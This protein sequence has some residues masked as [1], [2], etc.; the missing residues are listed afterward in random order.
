MP[1]EVLD[2]TERSTLDALSGRELEVL[3]QAARGLSNRHIAH[4]LQLSEATVKRHLANVYNKI[5]VGSRG[6]AMNKALHEGWFSTRDLTRESEA[7]EGH[8]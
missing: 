8:D 3:S 1:R 6:E 2:R 5:K 4:S 7:D